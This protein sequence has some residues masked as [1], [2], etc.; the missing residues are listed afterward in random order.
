MTKSLEIKQ[1]KESWQSKT[2]FKHFHEYVVKEAYFS[3]RSEQEST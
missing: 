3:Q 2:I 1:K